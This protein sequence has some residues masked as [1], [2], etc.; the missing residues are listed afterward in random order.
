MDQ[1]LSIV[2][3]FILAMVRYPELQEKAQESID[4]VC[5]GRLPDY[6][7]YDALPYVHALV[8]ES[9]RWNPVVC[10][11]EYSNPSKFVRK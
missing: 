1:T 5:C 11:S 6:S 8:K 10:L 7:D 4:R 9:L 3:S 2:R